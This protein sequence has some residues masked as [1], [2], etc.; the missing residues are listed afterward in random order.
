MEKFDWTLTIRMNLLTLKTVG[1]WPSQGYKFD[2]YTLYALISMVLLIDG[3]ILFQVMH[4][5]FDNLN[6]ESVT[7]PIF[8][9]VTQSLGSMKIF[10]FMRN[11]RTIKGLID[12][13]ND[14]LFQP[15]STTQI[16]LVSPG[17]SI[18]SKTYV[19]FWVLVSSTV[20]LWS[21]FPILDK[22]YKDCRLPFLA[23]YP[24]DTG[25]SPFYEIAYLHQVAG[26]YLV[27][28]ASLNIDTLMAAL[29]V[30]IGAQCD[31]LSDNLRSFQDRQYDFSRMFVRCLKRH[32]K[33]LR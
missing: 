2:F 15:K 10:C 7:G 8:I 25:V 6:L 24:C 21:V 11:I 1:L 22:S 32:K 9:I 33:I 31:I 26:I 18:W 13:L 30:Y 17:L 23:R 4:I 3:S 12:D 27:A 5:V 16:D 14:E 20:T 29:M 28:I 19:T